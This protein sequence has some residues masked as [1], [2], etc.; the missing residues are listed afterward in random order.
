MTKRATSATIFVRQIISLLRTLANAKLMAI[1]GKIEAIRARF[2]V[3]S[4]L[5]NKKISLVAL[6]HKI[7]SLLPGGHQEKIKT[8][9]NNKGDDATVNVADQLMQSQCSSSTHQVHQLHQ[10]QLQIPK[11]EDLDSH[12][13][14]RCQ[15]DDDDDGDQYPDLTHSLFDSAD[16][17]DELDQLVLQGDP[18]ASVIDLVRNSKGE[19]GENFSLEAEIDHVADLFIM[20]FHKKMRMQKLESFKRYQE[21]LERST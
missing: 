9:H 7:H 18:N 6:S 16:D 21:M 10:L 11:N 12:Y 19:G 20:K 1:K 3:F 17:D 4:L 5:R 2:L 13:Y 15:R 14:P 8:G